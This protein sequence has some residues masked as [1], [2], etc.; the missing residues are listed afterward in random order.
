MVGSARTNWGS[1]GSSRRGSH[2]HTGPPSG[3][4]ST[5]RTPPSRLGPSPFPSSQSTI[6]GQ[7]SQPSLEVSS[8]ST[9]PT[10]RSNGPGTPPEVIPD[11][12]P[13]VQPQDPPAADQFN[14]TFVNIPGV[15]RGVQPEVLPAPAPL[16]AW[17][18]SA[19][20]ISMVPRGCKEQFLAFFRNSIEEIE[21]ACT[22]DP[23][24]P[25]ALAAVQ[26]FL[27]FP[28]VLRM[29]LSNP[30]INALL[31]RCMDAPSPAHEL[32]A[33]LYRYDTEVLLPG[34]LRD[35]DQARV[36]AQPDGTLT[37]RVAR[38]VVGLVGLNKCSLA[39]SKLESN[40]KREVPQD[41]G[42]D[43]QLRQEIR[44]SHPLFNAQ[45]DGLG[46]IQGDVPHMVLESRDISSA[47]SSVNMQS[48][49][50]PTP[51]T[52]SLIK[53]V[54]GEGERELEQV[55]RLFNLIAAGRAGSTCWWNKSELIAIARPGKTARPIAVA[56]CWMRI[57]SKTI[58]LKVADVSV[59]MLQPYQFG[60]GVRCGMEHIIHL[61][62]TMAD[63][64]R[65]TGP[66][67]AEDVIVQ[68]DCSNAFNSISRK[69][70]FDKI[71]KYP[72][73]RPLA[74]FFHWSYGDQVP[75]HD[76]KG[77]L[78]CYSQCGVRQGD[79]LGPLFFVFGILEILEHLKLR[80]PT[81]DVAAYLDD[82][83]VTGPSFASA[84][85]LN[86][87]RWA[88][89][90]VGIRVNMGKTAVLCAPGRPPLAMLHV[91]HSFEGL[92]ILGSPIGSPEFVRRSCVEAM[93]RYT[94]ILAHIAKFP[95][96]IAFPLVQGCI[97][98]RPTHLCRTTLPWANGEA[99]Q[100]F[101]SRI[102][103]ILRVI[104]QYD[105]GYALAH[106]VPESLADLDGREALDF[107]ANLVRQ[108]AVE[109]GGMH[110]RAAHEIRESA[111]SASWLGSVKFLSEKMG[112]LVAKLKNSL[113][114]ED[115]TRLLQGPDIQEALNHVNMVTADDVLNLLAV[116]PPAQKD[117]YKVRAKR[118]VSDL[119][120]NIGG[121]RSLMAY[122]LS[123]CSRE[124]NLWN[125]SAR[126]FKG[127]SANL[128]DSDFATNLRLQL[129]NPP[130]NF[131][132]NQCSVRCMCGPALLQLPTG[133][134]HA[135]SCS[136]SRTSINALLPAYQHVNLGPH[137]VIIRRHNSIRDALHDFIKAACP[138][139]PI[140]K[141][142]LLPPS[143]TGQLIA[144]LVVQ[145]GGDSVYLDVV[146]ANPA[147]Q[148]CLETRRREPREQEKLVAAD[149]AEK[150]KVYKYTK[151]YHRDNRLERISNNLIPFALEATGTLGKKAEE[152]VRQMAQFQQVIPQANSKL[153]WA[154]RFFLNRVS[155][156]CAKA[157]ADLVSLSYKTQRADVARANPI[158]EL[159]PYQGE[160]PL[161][162]IVFDN[163]LGPR[164]HLSQASAHS[165][166]DE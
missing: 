7:Q 123:N 72:A 165:N 74:R 89:L 49:S 138:Q 116:S 151:S 126:F 130:L 104:A 137:G 100:L 88:L 157:R 30:D 6:S 119:K 121:D 125:S 111:Y 55:T 2:S 146:V 71:M 40:M 18:K 163:L 47:L 20:A 45:I 39:L 98:L 92:V 4:S 5:Q 25:H 24:S 99:L 122:Y 67:E 150:A 53:H 97:N 61:S 36:A 139:A 159:V 70:I 106:P 87:L 118:L 60:V 13:Q 58:A 33:R 3:N 86:D 54:C 135:L 84:Y 94:A 38:T 81:I 28:L 8:V 73:L 149:K 142:L 16:L 117:F 76:H 79:P 63:R 64:I 160:I 110:I 107:R 141:E 112:G 21:V 15:V 162:F 153:Q 144:D 19:R 37:E 91:R 164:V 129:L 114:S 34:R 14:R 102:S 155:I 109:E 27:M 75:L 120:N 152:M 128:E 11:I 77:S 134:Y 65:A 17:S 143:R 133:Q 78:V 41:I 147:N 136:A 158:E 46:E 56:N 44:D 166:M 80:H 12:G 132:A 35:Q 9:N 161:D 95:P 29:D 105:T 83:F 154:R 66:D 101:D 68:L 59:R 10:A 156:I 51:W 127:L 148:S 93:E 131:V 43:E 1:Q 48:S 23:L 82:I 22:I 124:S 145:V 85:A 62:Q 26:A 96:K 52:Y 32:L 90:N 31:T 113:M 57:L 115:L 42:A 140:Q 69:A 103:K 50:G 108:L